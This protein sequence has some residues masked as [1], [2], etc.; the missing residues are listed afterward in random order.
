VGEHGIDDEYV[1][2][3]VKERRRGG[4]GGSGDLDGRRFETFKQ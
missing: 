2:E 4:E 1:R 3:K